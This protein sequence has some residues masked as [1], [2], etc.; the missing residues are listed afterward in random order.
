MPRAA[1]PR[2]ALPLL[3]L[4]FALA[5]LRGTLF[6]T[7]TPLLAL[8]NSFDQ[9]RYSGCFDL[10]P[11]R[12]IAIRSDTNSPQAPFRWYAFR[13]N[14]QPLCYGSTELAFQAATVVAYRV[15][16]AITGAAR[17]DVRWIGILRLATLLALTAGLCRAWWARGLWGGA[18][19]NALALPLLLL[20]PANTLYFSTFYA[21]ATALF[22]LYALLNL[23]LLWHDDR[24][25]PWRI[26][27]LMGIALA[28]ALA[29]IQHLALPLALAAVLLVH[30]RLARA[31]GSWQ[32]LALG[33]G[34]LLGCALQFAQLARDDPLMTSIRSYNR[35]D[36][37]FTALL[38]QV[39][40]AAATLARLGLPAHCIDYSG[41]LAWQLPDLAEKVCP[42][43]EHV[44]RAAVLHELLR[45]PAA[46][47]RLTRAS[48]RALRA[49]LAPNLGTVEGGIVAPL[50]DD[51]LT[52]ARPL[53]SFAPLRL[54]VFGLPLLAAVLAL[55]HRGR[56]AALSVLIGSVHAATLTVIVLGDGL[57]DV[58]KQGHLIF[59]AGLWWCFA[60][61]SVLA[62][63]RLRR[64]TGATSPSQRIVP[65]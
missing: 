48:V 33:A 46:A 60:V 2:L 65:A 38:P 5:L 32:G 53:E 45:E 20:D 25:T 17:F 26:A 36:V 27:A 22:A 61:A 24:P 13:A 14:P 49:W 57:A 64:V 41:K 44:G 63:R 39:G 58:P 18:L 15:D 34:A 55:R 23:V 7:H 54:A 40:D 8:A 28:L 62:W 6:L 21:E 59:N 42:G 10:F 47:L 31:H 50:P 1:P 56:L 52:L 19:I 35:A 12:P 16:S 43:I 51:V 30:A 11:D 37:I 4:G 29:K 9:A 3:V